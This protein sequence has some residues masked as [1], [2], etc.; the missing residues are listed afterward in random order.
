VTGSCE[1]SIKPSGSIKRGEFHDYLRKCWHFNKVSA[2]W[3]NF[4]HWKSAYYRSVEM[5][6]RS[7]K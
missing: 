1:R 3:V 6:G 5:V 4:S 2:P 7:E